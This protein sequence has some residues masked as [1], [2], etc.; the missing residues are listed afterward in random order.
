MDPGAEGGPKPQLEL[1]GVKARSDNPAKEPLPTEGQT[2][3]LILPDG[4]VLAHNITP[5]A[6]DLL[7]T[8]NPYD[9]EMKTRALFV[10]SDSSS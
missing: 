9:A 6:A 1:L 3:L 10:S 4:R 5:E 7:A 8:L 2:E